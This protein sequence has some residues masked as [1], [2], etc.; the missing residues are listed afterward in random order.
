M[1]KFYAAL[2]VNE[3]MMKDSLDIDSKHELETQDIEREFGWL[4]DSGIFLRS[5]SREN[6]LSL[7]DEKYG[8]SAK[9]IQDDLYPYIGIYLGE[10]LITK[11]EINKEKGEIRTIAYLDDK[12]EVEEPVITV[13]KEKEEEEE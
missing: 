2:E 5:L 10:D 7:N 6:I 13:N 1:K 9:V 3:E 8:L 11:V 12:R 4:R